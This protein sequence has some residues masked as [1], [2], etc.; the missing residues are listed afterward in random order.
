M[1]SRLLWLVEDDE[2]F[3]ESIAYIID[4]NSDL[5]V[6]RHFLSAEEVLAHLKSLAFQSVPD[7][8]L[9]DIQLPEMD[10]VAL[11]TALGEFLPETPVVMMT[12][13]DDQKSVVKA[14]NAGAVGYLVKGEPHDKVL[15]VI[16]AGLDG[17]FLVVGKATQHV[18]SHF[19]D[20]VHVSTFGLTNRQLE[21]LLLMCNG[22]N[23]KQVAERLS[24]SEATAD[25]H[26]RNIYRK[27]GVRSAQAAV[28]V[29]Y[30]NGLCNGA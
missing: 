19:K 14:L 10:G 13:Q 3:A 25:N 29:A 5:K 27:L 23:K 30:K 2:A 18:R 17:E 21:V 22:M 26:F 9:L 24:I 11:L 4:G 1:Q 15:K 20:E 7:M 8:V 6:A 12:L 16:R 28:A